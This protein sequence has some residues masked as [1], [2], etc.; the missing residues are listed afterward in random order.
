V[1]G[2]F[3]DL[4]CECFLV[5]FDGPGENGPVCFLIF[6]KLSSRFQPVRDGRRQALFSGCG[7]MGFSLPAI[8]G[9]ESKL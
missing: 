2:G 4:V 9:G 5:R 1:A 8:D 7:L 6:G 3:S